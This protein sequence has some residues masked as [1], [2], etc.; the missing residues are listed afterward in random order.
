MMSP[1]PC[2][3]ALSGYVA[4]APSVGSPRVYEFVTMSPKT[5]ADMRLSLLSEAIL[6]SPKSMTI[7]RRTHVTAISMGV[8]PN[9]RVEMAVRMASAMKV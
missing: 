6:D 2:M 5:A 1:L 4:A 9:E 7:A 8:M 3:V